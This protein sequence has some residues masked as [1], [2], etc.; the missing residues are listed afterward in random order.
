MILDFPLQHILPYRLRYRCR[1]SNGTKSRKGSNPYH[2]RYRFR[3][4]NKTKS[5]NIPNGSNIP[6][7]SNSRV[8]KQC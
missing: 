4:G 6:K 7:G 8:S 3:V 5:N 1:L 2:L